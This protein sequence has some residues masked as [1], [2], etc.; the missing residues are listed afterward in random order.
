MKKKINKLE[1]MEETPSSAGFIVR[2][3]Q[4]SNDFFL[5]LQSRWSGKWSFPKGHKEKNES[6]LSCAL[7][8]LE[9]ETS[10]TKDHILLENISPV[11]LKIKLE[12]PTK[13]C[14]SGNK[15]VQF[16]FGF[17]KT[18][19]VIKLSREHVGYKFVSFLYLKNFVCCQHVQMIQSKR[20]ELEQVLFERKMI[21]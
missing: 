7:R 13:K 2:V 14:P 12:K 15:V 20:K 5:I 9:E 21:Y 17:L 3:R 4:N 18:M 16:F 19:P 10:I 6:Y 1:E 8:E 11:I